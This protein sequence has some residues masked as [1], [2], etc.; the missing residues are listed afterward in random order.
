MVGTDCQLL[1]PGLWSLQH[2]IWRDREAF[3]QLFQQA[4]ATE[5]AW[6]PIT[7][8]LSAQWGHN[9]PGAYKL[10]LQLWNLDSDLRAT[11][12]R[13]LRDGYADWSNNQ[14]V[15]DA[16][17]RFPNAPVTEKLQRAFDSLFIDLPVEDFD[18][19]YPLLSSYLAICALDT[20]REFHFV[21][22]YLAKNVKQHPVRCVAALNSLFFQIPVTRRYFYAKKP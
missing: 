4:L 17:E 14:L 3:F 12:L 18:R 13:Q 15:F 20:G 8:I 22:D 19:I 16:F 7:K 11:S 9:Q 21:I 10:L 2:L 1:A 5:E 6:E